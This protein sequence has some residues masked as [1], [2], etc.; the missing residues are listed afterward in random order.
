[1]ASELYGKAFNTVDVPFET[2]M[3]YYSASLWEIGKRSKSISLLDTLYG[4]EW[5]FSKTGFFT[6]IDE[7]TKDSII[8]LNKVKLSVIDARRANNP[9]IA[10]FD[11]IEKRDQ[12]ARRSFEEVLMEFPNDTLKL[13]IAWE[14]VSKVDSLNLVIIDSLIN[15]NGFMGGVYFPANPKIMHLSMLHQLEWVYNNPSI[16]IKA[17]KQ[18]R[19]LPEDFAVAYDKAMLIYAEDTVVRYGQFNSKLEGVSPEEV[20]K[21]AKSIGVSPYFNE[22]VTFPRKKGKQ[23]KKHLYYE[24]F[25]REKKHFSCY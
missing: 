3:Y 24:Y 13:N 5:I 18:G 15:A 20:F 14:A 12:I 17:I 21:Y 9:I 1:M 4:I 25:E 7:V 22:W 16:F 6:G 11:S 10:I 19:L 8:Q 2:D 23:P